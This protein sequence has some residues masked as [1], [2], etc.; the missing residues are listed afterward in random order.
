[1]LRHDD[2]MMKELISGIASWTGGVYWIKLLV[3]HMDHLHVILFE[4]IDAYQ[5]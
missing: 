4:R 5:T 3:E 2:D 1:M